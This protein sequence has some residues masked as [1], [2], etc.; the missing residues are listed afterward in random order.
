MSKATP[1]S[2]LQG[3][4]TASNET[5]PRF[6][7]L[8][9]KEAIVVIETFL[10]AL[11]AVP[12]S[13]PDEGPA[14]THTPVAP[15]AAGAIEHSGT[16]PNPIT[17]GLSDTDSAKTELQDRVD[18]HVQGTWLDSEVVTQT[19]AL[20]AILLGATLAFGLSSPVVFVIEIFVALGVGSLT[21]GVFA[22]YKLQKE[23]HALEARLS[24][25]I[26][27]LS[28]PTGGMTAPKE[29]EARPATKVM[30]AAGA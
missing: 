16:L 18:L 20:G 26:N 28:D 9:K 29:P 19:I 22:S 12:G 27:R 25:E 4:S 6:A 14:S 30:G 1:V 17:A 15:A 5:D 23:T 11:G 3:S 8:S 13:A 10:R 2:P 7:E 21:V 24:H